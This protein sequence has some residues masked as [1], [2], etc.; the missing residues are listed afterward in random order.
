MFY[1]KITNSI[2]KQCAETTMPKCLKPLSNG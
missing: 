2:K 1:F